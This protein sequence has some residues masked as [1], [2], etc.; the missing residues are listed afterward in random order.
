MIHAT[1]LCKLYPVFKFLQLGLV[2][3]QII[4][5]SFHSA[6]LLQPCSR[7]EKWTTLHAIG[8]LCGRL[9]SQFKLC[10]L[11]NMCVCIVCTLA[12]G[13]GS[14]CDKANKKQWFIRKTIS[15][16]I[17]LNETINFRFPLVFYMYLL[18]N[19]SVYNVHVNLSTLRNIICHCM[20]LFYYIKFIYMHNSTAVQIIY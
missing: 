2:Y 16:S 13:K 19:C 11:L 15:Y 20:Q 3:S 7:K 14:D 9:T 5:S 10:Q 1:L 12:A 17:C 18:E 4:S 6:W 8:H